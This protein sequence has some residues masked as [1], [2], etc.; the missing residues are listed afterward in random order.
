MLLRSKNFEFRRVESLN[1]RYSKSIIYSNILPCFLASLRLSFSCFLA[2]FLKNAS[3][4]FT[5]QF[6][7]FS[8]DPHGQGS[9]L[10]TFRRRRGVATTLLRKLNFGEILNLFP[11]PL[12]AIVNI[13]SNL[14]IPAVLKIM[15]ICAF[16][17]LN[18]KLESGYNFL[19]LAKT[20][21]GQLRP[22]CNTQEPG[23]DK[24]TSDND[25]ES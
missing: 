22:V 19:L 20:K 9:F 21:T 14:S 2:I 11:L 6:L 13:P 12:P 17:K 1:I 7:Y 16:I 8:P 3:P 23:H 25:I 18:I 10:P 5:Q 4:L 24:T 15:L